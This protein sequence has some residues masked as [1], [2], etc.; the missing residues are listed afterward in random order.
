MQPML[1]KRRLLTGAISAPLAMA[2]LT[3]ILLWH[4]KIQRIYT[5][6]LE[7][8]D[9]VLNEAHVAKGGVLEAQNA[10]E[11]Y[12]ASS[13]QAY[14][15]TMQDAM[16]KARASLGRLVTSIADNPFQEHRVVDISDRE[17]RWSTEI[18]RGLDSL[19]SKFGS[20]NSAAILKQVNP[21][22][23]SVLESFDDL[24]S[25]ETELRGFRLKRRNAEER[26]VLWLVPISAA[27]VA[28]VLILISWRD[29][30]VVVRDYLSALQESEDANLR[31]NN[32]LA[33]VSHEL[34]N[35]LNLILLWTRLLLS[36]ERTEEK[37]VRG[38][39]AIERAAQ[40]QAQ[41]IEDLLEFAKIE[42][43]RLRLD[44]QPTDLPSVVRAGVDTTMPAAEAKSIDLH[45]IIDPRAGMILGDPNRL[46]QALWN[47]LSNALKFTPKGGKI[48]VRLMRINSHIELAVSD[49]GKGI[50]SSFL[51][52]VF[53]RFWQADGS[54]DGNRKGMGL[55]L[56][57]VKHIITM[58]GGSVTAQS[59]GVGK[60]AT[61]TLRLPLP[62]TTDGFQDERRR[63]P[64]VAGIVGPTRIPRLP[65]IKML[66]VDDDHEATEA[67]R[68]LLKSL[69]AEVLVAGSADRALE[70][71]SDQRPDV[72]V[73]D[74]G[75]PGR[76][77]LSLARE[78]RIREHKTSDGRLPLV[79]LTAYG[80][81][82]DKVEIFAAGFDSHV[83]KPVDPAELAAVIKS[84]IGPNRDRL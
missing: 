16:D 26:L 18:Q 38:L 57:I 66:V 1:V 76:D 67:L 65:G 45:V 2:A 8:S 6:W 40:S 80:R 52:Y 4:L 81:V 55:G 22:T 83:V 68:A 32:F 14:L 3:V 47:L 37:T 29:I 49:T 25:A 44:L 46:Q 31:N 73:S 43:G 71:L 42:S 61:F 15:A 82:E 21:Y 84:V 33:T 56:A 19:G 24:I 62:I 74:I 7:H 10:L 30:V 78:I 20:A 13:D 51:P 75:M 60:G 64:T 35:P 59:Q 48:Q 58:H 54:G 27:V 11:G 72:V 9:R 53:D 70:I 5:Q 28:L 69:G 34:R 17:G 63:H 39:A 36:G 12:L 79:A 77:G 23:K 41:L 50:E